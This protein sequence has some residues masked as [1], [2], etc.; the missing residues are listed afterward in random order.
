MHWTYH[1]FLPCKQTEV[2]PT[3]FKLCRLDLNVLT[4]V[5]LPSLVGE[6]IKSVPAMIG[7]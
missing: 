1:C 2:T 7:F 6:T 4:A 5:L 3:N